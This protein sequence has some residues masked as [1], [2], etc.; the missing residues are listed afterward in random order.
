MSRKSKLYI[1]D[2]KETVLQYVMSEEIKEYMQENFTPSSLEFLVKN[3]PFI[4]DV[5]N[6][7]PFILR[8]GIKTTPSIVVNYNNNVQTM[9]IW[10]LKTMWGI[11]QKFEYYDTFKQFMKEFDFTDEFIESINIQD[12]L[13]YFVID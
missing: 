5:E 9:S 6:G 2:L 12:V 4:L 8:E 13:Y 11:Q 7:N 1:E 10:F 3:T